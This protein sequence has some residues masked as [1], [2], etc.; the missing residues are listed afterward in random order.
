[1]TERVTVELRAEAFNLLNQVVFGAPNM[2]LSSGQF[3]ATTSQSNTPRRLPTAGEIDRV[4]ENDGFS[5]GGFR[6]LYPWACSL[7]FQRAW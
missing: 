6:C 5:M 2:T 1:M 7:H 3:G 4:V